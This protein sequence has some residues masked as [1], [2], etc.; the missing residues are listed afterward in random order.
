V[1]A[2][3]FLD[4]VPGTVTAPTTETC[5]VPLAIWNNNGGVA[6]HRSAGLQVNVTNNSNRTILWRA[7]THLELFLS[8]SGVALGWS[9]KGLDNQ[10]TL[11]GAR[12]QCPAMPAAS[13]TGPSSNYPYSQ[14]IY[15]GGTATMTFTTYE[16]TADGTTC[17]ECA[18]VSA[19]ADPRA[20][21]SGRG[22][23]VRR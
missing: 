17:E 3:V 11:V 15:G 18:E 23:G 1:V 6:E 12:V 9:P 20:H 21:A 5:S 2:A 10:V 7:N 8:N 16:S 19:G 4:G 14:I 13:F 22:Q